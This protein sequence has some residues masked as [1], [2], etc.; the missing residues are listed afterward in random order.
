[1]SVQP[2]LTPDLTDTRIAFADRSDKELKEAEFL[3]SM[4]GNPLLSAA[5]QKIS[6]FALSIGLPITGLVKRTIF[7]QFCGGETIDEALRTAERLAKSH[8]GTILDF[9][10]EGQ[11]DEASLNATAA[12]ILRTIEVA[13]TRREIPFCVFKPTGISRHDL[14]EKVSQGTALSAGEEKEWNAVQGRFD[15]LCKAAHD[16]GIPILIDA[17]ESWIQQAVDDLV[18]RMMQRYNRQRPIVFNTI[19]FYRHDRVAFLNESLRKAQAGGYHLGIKLVRGAY[20]EKE[21]ERAKEKGY[22]SPI[23][24]DKPSVDKAYD[25][26]LRICVE[27]IDRM[28]IVSGTHNERSSILLT[29]LISENGLRRNDDRIW[30]SQLLGMS[31][32]IS[33]NL[34]HAGFNVVKYVPYGPVKKVLPYLIRRAAENT[35]VA[36]QT[37]RELRMIKAERVRRGGTAQ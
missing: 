13:R 10:A 7:K 34:S 3:F 36:G 26:G 6:L 5:G 24:P 9:S 18:E 27:N 11:D 1:M 37:G 4:I 25:E 33:Y 30:F 20:M 12:E 29:E 28:A 2:E 15:R 32:N 23:H 17:E 8:I 16:A 35:S 21:R 19:Q 22:P 31:D 14:L